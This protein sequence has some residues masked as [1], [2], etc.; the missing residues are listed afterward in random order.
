MK[1]ALV[2]GGSGGIGSNIVRVLKT[3]GHE[4]MAPGRFELDVSNEDSIVAFFDQKHMRYDVF[5]YSAGINELR[6][7]MD[8]D[9]ACL[10]KTLQVN[11]L[12]F[13]LLARKCLTGMCERGFGRIVALNSLYGMVS[14]RRRLP[15]A[16][17]KHA[18]TGAIQT[19]ALEVA[20]YGVL[21]NEVSPG[22]IRTAM[23][24]KNNSP[25]RIKELESAIPL[26]RMG[27]GKDIAEVVD[28]LCSEKNTYITG[29]NIVV[30][31][32][33]MAGGWQ[34]A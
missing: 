1:K 27:T 12:G 31:G 20:S 10:L 19:L 28:F 14:R 29:Q 2:I 33:Y 30:D 13:V 21:V 8:C 9:E 7:F 4:V 15:Y 5:V 26:G 34:N 3:S 17:S 6:N 16:I 24:E 18:L 23:T 22:F 11:T 32:G 25:E